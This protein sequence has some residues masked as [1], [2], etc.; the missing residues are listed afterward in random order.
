MTRMRPSAAIV[1]AFG[2][3][4]APE[5]LDGGQGGSWRAGDV[6]L[7]PLDLTESEL[8]WQAQV[9]GAIRC[10]GFRLAPPRLAADGSLVVDGWTAWDAMDGHHEPGR[11]ADIIATGQR[12][13][14]ALAEVPRP[15]FIA[16]RTNHWALADRIAWGELT[17]DAV[18]A[19]KHLPRLLAALRPVDAPSRLVHSDLTGNVLFH[20]TLPPA[21]I[22]FSPYWRPEPYGSA[23]VVC[24]ALTWEGADER[25][26]DAVAHIDQFGQYLLRAVIFRA[27]TDQLFRAGQQHRSDHAD[28]FLPVVELACRLAAA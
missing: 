26:L 15:D 22:D 24:D 20:D 23:V 4:G 2:A 6:V 21:V 1:A 19:T 9:L 5:P 18:P 11:W 7:K 28:E 27:V 12:F 14:A 10:D 25:L 8:T 17:P 13:H 3:T 16:R